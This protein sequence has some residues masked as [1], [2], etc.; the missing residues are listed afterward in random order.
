MASIQTTG[1]TSSKVRLRQALISSHTFTVM[2]LMVSLEIL[3]KGSFLTK[4]G[5]ASIELI[6]GGCKHL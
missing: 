4:Q 2:L 5:L 1:Q 3:M 6:L